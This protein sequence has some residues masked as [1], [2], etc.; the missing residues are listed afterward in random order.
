M[1]GASAFRHEGLEEGA[2]ASGAAPQ[3]PGKVA[4]W[5]QSTHNGIVFW[6]LLSVGTPLT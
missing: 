1:T 5:W 2:A 3:M 4:S 6:I